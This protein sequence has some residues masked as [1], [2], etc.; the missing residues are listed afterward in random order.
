M[1]VEKPGADLFYHSPAP[2][3]AG[4]ETAA[5]APPC[6]SGRGARDWAPRA[7]PAPVPDVAGGR[8]GARAYRTSGP[9]AG[10]RVDSIVCCS[11]GGRT[12]T[13][14]LRGARFS[15]G[16]FFATF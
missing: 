9:E 5:N 6:R 7:Q 4:P 3:P 12:G 8:S 2:Q 10:E 15:Y 16:V 13:I 1:K 11:G 14:C